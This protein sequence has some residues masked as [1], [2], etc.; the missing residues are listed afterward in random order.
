MA[1]YGGINNNIK[2]TII[3]ESYIM[4]LNYI[5]GLFL[6]VSIASCIEEGGN[7]IEG[8][9][10]NFVR[11]SGAD[12]E[13]NAIG[14]SAR[15]GSATL[16]MFT[17]QRDANSESSLNTA[18]EVTLQ[19]KDAI[20][21]DYN[22]ANGTEF[23]PMPASL[24]TLKDLKLSF[25]P[26][27]FAKKVTITVDPA[28]FDLSKSYALGIIIADAS[29]GFQ[30][31][32]S[33]KEG[34]FNILVK[35]DYDGVYEVTGTMVDNASATLS[36]LF[37]MNYHLV[38]SGGN[39]VDGYDPD[40]WHDRFIPILSAGSV[41]GYG[42]YAPVFTFDLSTNKITSVVNFYGQPAGN[43]R[44]AELD[45]S[46]LNRW[47]PADRS[48]D[49][50]FFMKQTSVIPTPPNIRVEFNWHMEYLGPR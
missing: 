44:S 5:L 43:T 22:A 17:V 11:I 25:A 48:I 18:S 3:K 10:N 24:Y 45:P 20:I 35:N 19:L 27:E 33:A 42:S 15:P 16:P 7:A 9:G 14:F 49:V 29:N 34:L 37:P 39:T 26:G 4:K 47:N 1:E 50:K 13:V 32:E 8:I 46:G 30:I 23:D 36:G 38:T 21:T 40:Y 28:K 12:Q 6:F 41:S 31:I 2:F